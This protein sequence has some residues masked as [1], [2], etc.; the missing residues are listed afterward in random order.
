M[1]DQQAFT[2]I[3]G[4]LLRHE[5]LIRRI[6]LPCRLPRYDISNLKTGET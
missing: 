1:F 4:D 2:W 5:E 6:G 3:V